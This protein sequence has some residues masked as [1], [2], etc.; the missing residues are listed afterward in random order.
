MAFTKSPR[1]ILAASES[2]RNCVSNMVFASGAGG[3]LHSRSHAVVPRSFESHPGAD[4]R[5]A[6]RNRRCLSFQA[7]GGD[8]GHAFWRNSQRIAASCNPPLA[9]RPG[10]WV[11]RA[12]VH[13]GDAGRSE[14]HTSELQSR[15]HLVCRLLLEK[16]K[17]NKKLP[18]FK[19]KNKK[20]TSKK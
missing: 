9:R 10:S 8:C 20:T 3:G 4:R 16:K 14:E 12:C 13:G 19:K 6:R 15:P 5:H 7:S 11:A 17:K 18:F 2:A 1:G